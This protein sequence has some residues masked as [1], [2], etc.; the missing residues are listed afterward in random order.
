MACRISHSE[1][2]CCYRSR[3]WR[4]AAWPLRG[5]R[6]LFGYFAVRVRMWCHRN[7]TTRAFPLAW[8][9]PAPGRTLWSNLL[10]PDFL[11][12][13]FGKQGITS[14][15]S[16]EPNR[17]AAVMTSSQH[18]YEIRPRKDKRGGDLISDALPFGRLWY[19]K[20][21]AVSSAIDYAKFRSRH[22]ALSFAFITKRTT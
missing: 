16:L 11:S 9:S 10:F 6:Q 13:T 20:R 3:A 5:N 1:S 12:V 17:L 19:G 7:L 14:N 2:C 21:N 18:V 8:T 22:V 15:Q 4:L